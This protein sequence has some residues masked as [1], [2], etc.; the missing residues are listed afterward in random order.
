MRLKRL[1]G[2]M[3]WV[4]PLGQAVSRAA[5]D[6]PSL[7]TSQLSPKRLVL[8]MQLGNTCVFNVMQLCAMTGKSSVWQIA[9]FKKGMLDY[10]SLL[11]LRLPWGQLDIIFLMNL[12]MLFRK[13]P[14]LITFNLCKENGSLFRSLFLLQPVF[15][16]HNFQ[17]LF[18]IRSPLELIW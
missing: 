3:L 8:P 9:Q 16:Y 15:L 7:T 12:Q 11:P 13:S 4:S 6:L 18:S 14:S 2:V 1:I 17:E 10:R 5:A